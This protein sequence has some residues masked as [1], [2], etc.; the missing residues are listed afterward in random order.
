MVSVVLFKL[1]IQYK[2]DSLRSQNPLTTLHYLQAVFLW[3]LES[4]HR[5]VQTYTHPS[6]VNTK[7]TVGWHQKRGR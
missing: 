7:R 1:L 5:Y 3:P 2:L 4:E 6:T